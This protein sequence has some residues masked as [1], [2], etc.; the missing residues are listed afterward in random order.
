LKIFLD[1]LPLAL[2]FGMFKYAEN[3]REWAAAFATSHLGF[4]VSGGTIGTQEAPVLLATVVV[5]LATLAQVLILKLMKQKIDAILW[6]SL[7]LVVVLGAATVYFHSETFIKWKPTVL[8]WAMA[9]GFWAS[10]TF[11]GKNALKAML[12]DLPLPEPVWARLNWLWIGFFS[13]MGVLNIW[14]ATYFSTSD[15]TNFKVFGSTGLMLIFMVGQGV[16]L[17]RHL[18]RAEEPESKP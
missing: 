9:A 3:H 12:K 7:A 1:F 11:W 2:F 5:M 8:Y 18:P 17:S 16:Y 10:A 14:V 6:V 13:L 15:W 4:M